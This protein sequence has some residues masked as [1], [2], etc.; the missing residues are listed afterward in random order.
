MEATI[1]SIQDQELLTAQLFMK[2]ALPVM[3]VVLTDDPAMAKK[4]S[5]V[6]AKVIIA[7]RYR[8]AW[9]GACLHFNKGELTISDEL[10]S[11]ADIRLLFNS[12]AKMNDML[13]GGSSLPSI[14]GIGKPILLIKVLS[15]LMSLKLMMPAARPRDPAKRNMKVKMALYMITTALSQYNK[16]G[17]PDMR[18]WTE[19][20]P[21]RIYQFSVEPVEKTGVAVYL[22]VKAGKTKAGRGI[23][24]RKNPFVHFRFNGADGALKVLLKD[25]EFVSGVKEGCVRIDGSPEYAA[26]LND[27]MAVLQN[28]MT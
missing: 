14:K 8:D 6:K 3:K 1:T 11:K 28:R 13:S 7:A 12:L 23:Y 10:P 4:F 5:S 16:A 17:S 15:L 19:K 18:A 9:F 20:Q 21:D 25:V 26:Q 24:T 2:A 22:R 27:L